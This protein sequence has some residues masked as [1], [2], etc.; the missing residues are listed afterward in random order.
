VAT[1][2]HATLANNAATTQVARLAPLVSNGGSLKLHDPVAV[3]AS[4]QD[5]ADQRVRRILSARFVGPTEKTS[6]AI[7]LDA[8]TLA[9]VRS[10]SVNIDPI[11]QLHTALADRYRIER[12]L[13]AGGMATVYLAHDLRHGRDVAMK[14]LRPDVGQSLGRDRFLREIHLAAGLTHPHILPLHD[15]G[16]ADGTLWF[17]MP[18]MRGDTLRDR[19]TAQ[20]RMPVDDVLL[21]VREV[22]DALDYAH[23]H[24]VVHRDIKPE[25]I[26]LH[27]G[28]A[29][30]ADFGIGKAVLAASSENSTF[31]QVGVTVGT[32]AYMSPE[33]AA[34]EEVDGRTDL[35]AL[36]CVLYEMLTGDV[37]FS[38][39][40][41]QATIA[42]RFVHTP[43][44]IA[45]VRPDV[46]AVLV[47]LVKQLLEKA[48][49]ARIA[50]GSA[51]VQSL[52][53]TSNTGSAAVAPRVDT[54]RPE[55]SRSIVVLP[56][57]N[58][59]ADADNGFVA[60]GLTEELITDLSQVQALRVIS[61]TTAMQYKGTSRSLREIGAEL[62]V[63]HAITGSLR[64][65]GSAL[66]VSAQLVDVHTD[67]SRWA[68]KY[69]GSMDDVFDMQERVSRAIVNA[70]HVVLSRDESERLGDRPIKNVRAF[71]LFVQAREALRAY[72]VARAEPLIV[73]AIEIEG[74]VPVLRALRAFGSLM[75]I[76]I[77]ASREPALFQQ[78]DDE[79]RALIALMPDHA[80][81]YALLGLLS[82][83]RGD[84]ITGVRALRRA[85][86]LDPSDADVR[87]GLGVALI[88][89]DRMDL[90]MGFEWVAL[91]PLSPLANV[92]VAASAWCTARPIDGL[93][94]MRE[95]VRLAPEGPIFHWG[96]G[97]TY[98]LLGRLDEAAEQAAWLAAHAP[99]FSYTIQLRALL[100]GLQG[101]PAEALELLHTVDLDS[102]DSH[103][104][105]HL[106]ESYAAAGDTVRALELLDRSVEMG[107][108]AHSA[109]TRLNPYFARLRE[110][111]G[112]ERV[113][114]KAAAR[115]A[116]FD[117]AMRES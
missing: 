55:T 43:P 42:R 69:N 81:G 24:D 27:E 116:A 99:H 3:V 29:V 100:A 98:C 67:E 68:D 26:L 111:P 52:R 65:A 91:D 113:A 114:A 60:D 96:L 17:T 51:V 21:L 9:G 115:V 46:P 110:T 93:A 105:A 23:R 58:V 63:R 97:T 102:L 28:H 57:E 66:R 10:R 87:F 92:L 11:A 13:G 85:L 73:R 71:E 70:L 14:V 45:T 88:A 16:D 34:G 107:F 86:A 90:R 33:Q 37:A 77:G 74:E 59:S 89:A 106:S 117:V 84:H 49:D 54:L 40:T 79:A 103:H 95:A 7:G 112:F 62:G 61:R 101:R 53:G 19:M 83:E 80:Y 47:R 6:V 56:F 5:G 64:R 44:S 32:P 12:E 18:L 72:D 8:R 82:Y 38:G 75:L 48:S 20:P 35:F 78:I 2:R 31:T 15:S 41:V 39:P 30:I 76:R 25:N 4:C 50:T 104:M 109:I 108:Y 22:A 1:L 36:G 94:Y